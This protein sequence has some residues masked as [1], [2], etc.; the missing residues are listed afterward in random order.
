MEASYVSET[1]N[2]H[3]FNSA[4]FRRS[5]HTDRPLGS[6]CG[7]KGTTFRLWAPTAEAVTLRLW[8]AGTGDFPLRTISLD[9]WEKGIWRYETPEN[10]D[11]T[12]YDYLVTVDGTT[13]ATADPYARAAGCNGQRSMVIQLER[14][15]PP[16]W[17]QDAPPPLPPEN[18]IWEMHV[19]EFSWD[20]ASGVPEEYRGKY[21]ALTLTDTTLNGDGVHPTCLGWLKELGITHV[22]LMPVYDYA[23][24]DEGG[25]PAMFNWGYDPLNYNVPEGSYASDAADGA[26]RI[27]ELKEAI[28]SLHR[29][30]FRVIMDVVYNHTY[31][32]DSWLWRTVPWYYLRQESDGTPSNGSGCGC[33]LASE[34]SMVAKYILDSVLYWAEEYH[35]DGFRFDLMGLLDVRLM[36]RIRKELDDRYG[37]GEKILLGEP[38]SAGSTAARLGTRLSDKWHMT[39]LDPGI[40][41]FVDNTRDM[42]KGNLWHEDSRGLVNGGTVDPEYL[43]CCISGWSDCPNSWLQAPTQAINY[44]SSHDDWTLWDRLVYTGDPSRNFEGHQENLLRQNKMAAVTLFSCIGNLFMLSGEEFARTKKGVKNSYNSPLD[45][46]MLDWT[47]A[48]ENIDLA[49]WYRGLIALRKSLPGLTDK[50]PKAADRM[51]FFWSPAANCTALLWDN[52]GGDCPWNT[53]LMVFHGG[54]EPFS[55]PLPAGRWAVLVDDTST[56]KWRAPDT[57]RESVLIPPGSAWILAS[58]ER[59]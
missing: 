34:R 9:R 30:G 55:L 3:G 7:P 33:D 31:Y 56:D 38:W 14:T 41:A 1:F 54:T 43:A 52:S 48:W 35:M 8:A 28:Q 24:V 50:S 19:K 57:V 45:I 47:R 23:T 42:V 18:I 25:N 51:R 13:R 6:C 4:H 21:K 59:S 22:Q 32:L 40:A 39:N 12:Y 37:A 26:V 58:R 29:A 10:L 44:L 16:E 2:Q 11:G 17:E 5:Y 53:L 27:R 36:N 46:G 15:N 49:R 20:P